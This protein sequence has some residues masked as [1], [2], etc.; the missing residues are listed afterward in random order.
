MTSEPTAFS[1]A[2]GCLTSRARPR[3]AR[4]AL[5]IATVAGLSLAAS[6]AG[7]SGGPELTGDNVADVK[8]PRFR[9]DIRGKALDQ[10]WDESAS[11]PQARATTRAMLKEMAWD[12]QNTPTELRVKIMDKLL[13]DPDE[14]NLADS[15]TMARLMIPKESSRTVLV[16]VCSVI[17]ARGW[18]DFTGPLIRSYARPQI[19]VPEKERCERGALLALY[20]GQSIEQI[21]YNAFVHP[22]GMDEIPGLDATVRLRSEA[23]DLLG[24]LDPTGSFRIRALQETGVPADDAVLTA[25]QRSAREVKAIPISGGEIP[26]LLSLVSA[27]NAENAA[28]WSEVSSIAARLD[29]EQTRGLCL[30]NLEPLRWAAAN[31]PQLLTSG[32]AALLAELHRRLDDRKTHR[33]SIDQTANRRPIRQDL[34]SWQDKLTWGDMLTLLAIDDVLADPKV[35]S[36]I[37]QQQVLDYQDKQTEYGGVIDF[38]GAGGTEKTWTGD[39]KATSNSWRARLFPPRSAQRF[40]DD[41]FIAST[42]MMNA[43]DRAL[44]I[45]H[46]HTQRYRNEDYAGP[47]DG[48]QEFA[49]SVGRSCVVFTSIREGVLNVDYY[50]PSGAIIDMGEILRP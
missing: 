46:F 48:D 19:L 1:Y 41:R 39:D 22:P 6:L 16:Y 29:D 13:H 47:S 25:I 43:G 12:V 15:K 33:R 9:W 32:R 40:A 27:E 35:R 36:Q 30:R 5:L 45:Y 8:N 11:N 50:Q 3:K 2:P 31:R 34:E 26:W 49:A 14:A 37:L 17:G 23:W 44:A 10:L 20:P 7:C 28:W 24:R 42:D 21:V 38:G 18:I 4:L